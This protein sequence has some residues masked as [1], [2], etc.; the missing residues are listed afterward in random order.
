MGGLEIRNLGVLWVPNFD[1]ALDFNYLALYKK[2]RV[3]ERQRERERCSFLF[4]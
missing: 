2:D 3:R 1:I 4:F